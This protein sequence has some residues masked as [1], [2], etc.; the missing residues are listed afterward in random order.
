[1]PQVSTAASVR[2][3]SDVASGITLG[4]ASG[5]ASGVASGI[6][7]SIASILASAAPSTMP[8]LVELLVSSEHEQPMVN[9]EA[10]KNK[11]TNTN[12]GMRTLDQHARQRPAMTW[13]TLRELLKYQALVGADAASFD[14][15]AAV[16]ERD[17]KI[18]LGAVGET[19]VHHC[20]LT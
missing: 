15:S 9:T 12:L 7:S 14:D 11:K 4:V 3:A 18:D 13:L 10:S 17:A 2:I 8:A 16:R 6:A 20:L 5:I 1:M 19:E